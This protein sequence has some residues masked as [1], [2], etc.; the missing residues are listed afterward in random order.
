MDE[1]LTI[2]GKCQCMFQHVV[3]PQYW[4]ID[5]VA[6]TCWGCGSVVAYVDNLLL[7]SP[8][9][10]LIE[11]RPRQWVIRHRTATQPSEYEVARE[12]ILMGIESQLPDAEIASMVGV[13]LNYVDAL[14]KSSGLRGSEP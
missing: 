6:L 5:T 9:R 14:A 7:F 8:R 12:L 13:P 2:C 10:A 4:P 11:H 3:S 1:V